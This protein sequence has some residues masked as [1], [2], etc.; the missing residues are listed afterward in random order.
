[1]AATRLPDVSIVVPCRNEAPFIGACLDSLLRNDYPHEC[2]E[3]LV[4]DG[5]S[6]DG[7]REVVAGYAARHP[8]I[9]L[10]DN[11]K[12]IT[13]AALNIALTHARGEV[14]IRMDA[15]AHCNSTYVRHAVNGLQRYPEHK[16]GGVWKIAPRE[17]TLV[18]RAI[19]WSM[20]HVFGVGPSAYRLAN[21][22]EETWVD[23][24]PYFCYRREVFDRIGEFNERLRRGQD[25]EF[26]L[27]HQRAGGRS[28]LIPSMVIHYFA[29]SDFRTFVR[30]NWTNGVWAVLPF[31]YSDVVPVTPRHLV[32][33]AFVGL[34]VTLV[35]TEPVST[36]GPALAAAAF[37]TY[38]LAALV[39]GIDIARR[40]RDVRYAFVMPVVFSALHLPY[41]MGSLWG[42]VK[43]ARVWTT[44]WIHRGRS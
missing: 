14:L 36:L 23:I 40:D 25:L 11:E 42:A 18:A 29:R 43:V 16:V 6:D 20:S 4:V 2:L 38:L 44:R 31:A 17:N 10:I 28:L 39:A 1:M 7:T 41:G 9:R 34:M 5:M 27:R 30:H 15:H 33:L 8:L 24:V 26:D 19:V 35:A 32:P 13:P 12:R 22:T 37:A 21:V 3:I